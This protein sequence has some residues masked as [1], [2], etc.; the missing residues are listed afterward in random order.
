MQYDHVVRHSTSRFRFD[1]HVL[2]VAFILLKLGRK[3]LL[4][5]H[6]SEL[7]PKHSLKQTTFVFV[8]VGSTMEVPD[9]KNHVNKNKFKTKSNRKA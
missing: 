6:A 4:H 8:D 1:F 3:A 9:L 5:A 2:R 7:N